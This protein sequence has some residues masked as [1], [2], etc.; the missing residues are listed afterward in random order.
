MCR[1]LPA[2]LKQ[3][4]GPRDKDAPPTFLDFDFVSATSQTDQVKMTLTASDHDADDDDN[5]DDDVDVRRRQ[6]HRQQD[7][8]SAAVDIGS[9]TV[10]S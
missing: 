9:A 8:V 1:S 5:D 2:K 3:G 7:V 6:H 10:H 4:L